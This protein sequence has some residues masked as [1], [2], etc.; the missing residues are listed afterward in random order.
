MQQQHKEFSTQEQFLSVVHGG[1]AETQPAVPALWAATCKA[2]RFAVTPEKLEPS[3]ASFRQR[4]R[5]SEEFSK[6]D[7]HQL[8]TLTGSGNLRL[9]SPS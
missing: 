2:A 6:D 1:V 8:T 7:L 5:S 3:L 9:D 4:F